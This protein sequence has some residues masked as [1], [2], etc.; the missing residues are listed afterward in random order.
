[1]SA[2]G[3]EAD[4]ETSADEE[5]MVAGEFAGATDEAAPEARSAPVPP[6]TP[7][8][9]RPL[10]RRVPAQN[11]NRMA[12]AVSPPTDNTVRHLLDILKRLP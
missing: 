7:L 1:M 9:T 6:P 11:P 2:M 4:E 3:R 8:P 12:P 10:P 5:L